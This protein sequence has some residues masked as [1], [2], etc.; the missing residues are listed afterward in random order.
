LKMKCLGLASLCRSIARQRSRLM[1]LKDRDANTRFFHLQ[2]CHRNRKSMITHLIHN[3][4]PIVDENLK[5]E[6]IFDHFDQI[7]GSVVERTDGVN[8]DCI[9]LPCG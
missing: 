8:L 5:A 9:G 4:V 1:Y 3:G 2:A 7:M 6:A